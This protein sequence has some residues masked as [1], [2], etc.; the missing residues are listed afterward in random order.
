VK[1]VLFSFCFLMTAL[2]CAQQK[3][4]YTYTDVQAMGGYPLIGGGIRFLSGRISL[5]FS[6]NFMPYNGFSPLT[7][8]TKG[9][10]LFYPLSGLYVGTG[11]GLLNEPEGL[12]KGV[13]GTVEGSLGLEWRTRHNRHL[14]LEGTAIAPFQKPQGDVLRVWPSL[15]FGYGF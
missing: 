13:S 8:H 2:V 1:K 11:L 4:F 12:I 15:T 14:F 3:P 6:G 9:Q 10:V 7:F 5:D